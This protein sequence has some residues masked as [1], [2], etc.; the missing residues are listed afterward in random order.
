MISHK[1]KLA[2][3]IMGPSDSAKEDYLLCACNFFS[4]HQKQIEIVNLDPCCEINKTLF[5]TDIRHSIEENMMNGSSDQIISFIGHSLDI[6][7][8]D[9]DWIAQT[10]EGN[11]T[12]Y[13]LINT[14]AQIEA[15]LFLPHFDHLIHTLLEKFNFRVIIVNVFPA[16]MVISPSALISAKLAMMSMLFSIESAKLPYISVFTDINT[17]KE[18]ELNQFEQ[19]IH[20]DLEERD[21]ILFNIDVPEEIRGISAAICD[22]LLN[23]E[24]SFVIDSLNTENEDLVQSFFSHLDDLFEFDFLNEE[25]DIEKVKERKEEY[26]EEEDILFTTVTPIMP[27]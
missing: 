26:A 3:F 4:Q 18:E 25:D 17:L 22:F 6:V 9:P 24:N 11:E 21:K 10:F 15:T 8:N 19:L 1:I 16:K 13:F 27:K 7:L 12:P 23:S 2:Q 14:P 5:T 20:N